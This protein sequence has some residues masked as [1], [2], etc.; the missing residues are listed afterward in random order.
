M[1]YRKSQ[2][3]T[4]VNLQ[5]SIDDASYEYICTGS[6]CAYSNYTTLIQELIIV[7][8]RVI[9]HERIYGYDSTI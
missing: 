2:H 6:L 5:L 9:E 3:T 1:S 4:I 7:K 8:T